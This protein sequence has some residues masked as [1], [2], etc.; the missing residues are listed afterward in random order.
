MYFSYDYI[1]VLGSFIHSC[2]GHLRYAK[3]KLSDEDIVEFNESAFEY[4][5]KI[6]KEHEE[7]LF[8][9]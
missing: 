9:V 8:N 4:L 7:L 6:Q 5:S 1:K 2:I 3:G